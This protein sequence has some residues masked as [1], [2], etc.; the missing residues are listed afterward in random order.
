MKTCSCED[1]FAL[2]APRHITF[3]V[4]KGET[5]VRSVNFD[6]LL[7]GGRKCLDHPLRIYPDDP[8]QLQFIDDLLTVEDNEDAEAHTSAMVDIC[9]VE[10]FVFKCVHENYTAIQVQD[11]E[12]FLDLISILHEGKYV[13]GIAKEKQVGI[14]VNDLLDTM[15]SR[16]RIAIKRGEEI[17]WMGMAEGCEADID[18]MNSIVKGLEFTTSAF[19]TYKG[20]DAQCWSGVIIQI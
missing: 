12:E 20:G 19:C 11:A 5:G 15:E 7:L 16:Q 18:I 8:R 2:N 13:V 1:L 14:T 4:I 3:E 6:K 9:N 17:V 10:Q